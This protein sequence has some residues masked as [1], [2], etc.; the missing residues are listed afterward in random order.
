MPAT[1]TTRRGNGAGKGDG[2][3]GPAKGA[4]TSRITKE[5]APLIQPLS[6]DAELKARRQAEAQDLLDH[7]RTLATTAKRQETQL[8]AAMAFVDRVLPKPAATT[9]V[10]GADGGPL[11]V[12]RILVGP[13]NPDAEG[14]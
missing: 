3:G 8:T 1:R 14:L 4:S 6:H 13:A 7:I 2:W 5:N 9:L 12:E 10:G 11:I